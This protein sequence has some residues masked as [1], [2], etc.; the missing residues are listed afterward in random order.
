MT[1]SLHYECSLEQADNRFDL[2]RGMSAGDPDDLF[3]GPVAGDFG[4][5]TAPSSRWWDGSA[6]S[7]QIE[8]NSVPGAAITVK[9][10]SSA[11]T[12]PNVPAIVNLLI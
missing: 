9:T 12:V 4:S 1:P 8:Q 3:G 2:E 7:L 5:F 10:R 6:S 11:G